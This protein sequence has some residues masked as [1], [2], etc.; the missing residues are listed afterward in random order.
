VAGLLAYGLARP[1]ALWLP[2]GDAT[3]AVLVATTLGLALVLLLSLW[4][5]H[6]SSARARLYADLLDRVQ[7]GLCVVRV[8]RVERVERDGRDTRL[9]LI[10]RN[11][12]AE[13]FARQV[14]PAGSPPGTS[15]LQAAYSAR[16]LTAVC[17]DVVAGGVARD[18]DDL[19]YDRPP[20]RPLI[21]A[22]TAFPLAP[23][24][25]GLSFTDVTDERHDEQALALRESQLRRSQELAHLGSWEWDL[26]LDRLTLSDELYRLLGHEPQTLSF[27]FESLLAQVH[28]AD[29]G[30]VAEAL[31]SLRSGPRLLRHQYRLLRRDG[32]VR[33]V[34]ATASATLGM[35]DRVVRLSGVV[36]DITEQWEAAQELQEAYRRLADSGEAE[37]LLLAQEIHDRPLQDLYGVRLGLAALTEGL[38]EGAAREGARRQ[39]QAIAEVVGQL[40]NICQDLRPPA[41]IPFGLRTSVQAYAERFRSDNP[42]LQL[43]L[44]LDRDAQQLDARTRL[45]LYRILQQALDNVVRHAEAEQVTVRLTL[46][47]GQVTLQVRDDGRGFTVPINWLDTARGG[48]LGLLGIAERA[49]AIG[50]R[51]VVESAPGE[52]TLVRVVA[53]FQPPEAERAEAPEARP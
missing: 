23:S 31:R 12:T 4:R 26:D 37:R 27:T 1:A 35:G 5:G 46:D 40:R 47:S 45:G 19:S 51:L 9:K 32:S 42:Q 16:E 15:L 10:A 14:L 22:V 49:A 43:D 41:L 3:L 18:L 17:R 2:P 48:H 34:A 21:L 29:R 25:V 33:I 13:D 38:P 50:G 20:G 7:I 52:G 53:P 36:Q 28:P 8:E 11:L 39:Q 30:E 24:I 6:R 44:D